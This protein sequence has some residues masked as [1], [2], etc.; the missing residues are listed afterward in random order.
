VIARFGSVGA[1]AGLALL[2]ADPVAA[3]KQLPFD[4]ILWLQLERTNP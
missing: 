3:G 2:A 1:T 4:A